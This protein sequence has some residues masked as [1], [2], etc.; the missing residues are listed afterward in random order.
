M[1]S[2]LDDAIG[3]WLD[4]EGAG[5]GDRAEAALARSLAAVGRRGPGRGFA[6]RTLLAAGLLEPASPAWWPVTVRMALAACLLV[7][8]LALVNLPVLVYAWVPVVRAA[9]LATLVPALHGLA[10]AMAAAFASWTF[11]EEIA[12]ALRASLGNPTVV[13]VLAANLSVAAASLVGLKRLLKTPEEMLP[14]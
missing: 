4:A 14:W 6:D 9:G 1:S 5:D 11:V 3:E 12:S 10:R 13:L 7:A 8:G 2:S